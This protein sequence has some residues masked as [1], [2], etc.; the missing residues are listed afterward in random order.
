MTVIKVFSHIIGLISLN[1]LHKMNLCTTGIQAFESPIETP[2]IFK[3]PLQVEPAEA[4]DKIIFS[5][6][7]EDQVHPHGTSSF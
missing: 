2:V 1:Q 7:L 5:N 4:S 3:T 6:F